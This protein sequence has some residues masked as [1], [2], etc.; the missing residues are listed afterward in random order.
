MKKQLL[1]LV[2]LLSLVAICLSATAAFAK[3]AKKVSMLY[4]LHAQSGS[5]AKTTKPNEFVLNLKK[6]RVSYFSDRPVRTTGHISK[7]HFID[8]WNQ[9]KDSFEKVHP[10]ASMTAGLDYLDHQKETNK[11][12][13]LSSPKEVGKKHAVMQFTIRPFGKHDKV[14]VGEYSDVVLF[15]DGMT[16][17]CN[18]GQGGWNC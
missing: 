5:I 1:P 2:L 11:F 6:T 12:I 16:A 4:V 17:M 14:K 7:H 18:Y 15:I 8:L 10:N 13:V 3:P 9:G